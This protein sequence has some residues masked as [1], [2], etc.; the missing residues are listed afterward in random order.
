VPWVHVT[1]HFIIWEVCYSMWWQHISQQLNTSEYTVYNIYGFLYF[2]NQ[3]LH[4]GELVH[5][6]DCTLCLCACVSA[7]MCISTQIQLHEIYI[8]ISLVHEDTHKGHRIWNMSMTIWYDYETQMVG[9]TT[10]KVS[11]YNEQL[12][13]KFLKSAH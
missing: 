8:I 9:L 12:S 5:K 4:H 10:I 3:E 2:L 13:F 7:C 11:P 1:M 6:P